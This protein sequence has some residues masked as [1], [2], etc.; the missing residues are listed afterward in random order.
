MTTT[1]QRRFLTDHLLT[2]ISDQGLV[3][4]DADGPD[5]GGWDAPP[6]S[7]DA[8]YTPYVV[9][10]PTTSPDSTGPVGDSHADIVVAYVVVGYG[11]SRPHVEHY[12]DIVRQALVAMTRTMVMLGEAQWRIQQARCSSIGGITKSEN[13]E[14]TEFSQTDVFVL[15]MSKSVA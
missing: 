1:I 9:L 6:D 15:Y 7:L 11:L 8:S 2:V 13:V 5:D 14:P 3:V 12:M 10:T 4:G